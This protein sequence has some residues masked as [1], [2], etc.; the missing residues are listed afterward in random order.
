MK[1]LKMKLF[2]DLSKDMQNFSEVISTYIKSGV[3]CKGCP[4]QGKGSVI[5][6]TNLQKPGPVHLAIVGLNP[7]TQE[8]QNKIPFVGG[9]GKILRSYF[10][11]IVEYMNLSYVIYNVILCHTPNEKSIPNVKQVAE[12][13]R[14]IVSIIKQNFP[15][16]ITVVLGDKARASVGAD[17][18]QITK[19]TGQLINGYFVMIHPSSLQYNPSNRI[20]FE[21]SVK[22]LVIMLFRTINRKNQYE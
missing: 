11:P 1:R 6:D 22:R 20:L 16:N 8:L 10:D 13:C 17:A 5:L 4:L 2:S 21:D 7:G 18:G 14:P 15:A 12:K 3:I 19:V 9:A